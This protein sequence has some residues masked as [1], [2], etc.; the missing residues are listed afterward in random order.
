MIYLLTLG[1]VREEYQKVDEAAENYI[2][3]LDKTF[4]VQ[5]HQPAF[6]DQITW[7][8]KRARECMYVRT[9][10]FSPWDHWIINR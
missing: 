5:Y 4:A 3:S 10:F 6:Q 7:W 2:D 1:C 9:Y 8:K